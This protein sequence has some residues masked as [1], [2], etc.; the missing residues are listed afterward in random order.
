MGKAKPAVKESVRLP[1]KPL[2]W[3]AF[4]AMP[5]PEIPLAK[6]KAAIEAEREEG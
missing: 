3:K 5:A 2:D 6:L 1:K 4:F